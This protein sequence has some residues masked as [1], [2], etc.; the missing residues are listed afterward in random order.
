MRPSPCWGGLGKSFPLGGTRS[1]QPYGSRLRSECARKGSSQVTRYAIEKWNL[2]RRY[3]S[4]IDTTGCVSVA[5]GDRVDKAGSLGPYRCAVEILDG[6][7]PKWETG[8]TMTA[9]LER[10]RAA[11]GEPKS[12]VLQY[13]PESSRVAGA[14]D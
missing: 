12:A 5:W 3:K 13:K 11:I 7:D 2:Q 1:A 10:V 9:V 14:P 8:E 6:V 4:E